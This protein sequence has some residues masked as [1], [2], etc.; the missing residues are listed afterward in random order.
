MT[1]NSNIRSEQT[2]EDTGEPLDPSTQARVDK[3]MHDLVHK[4][5]ISCP[6][7]F[8]W[9]GNQE[10]AD[11]VVLRIHLFG[12]MMREASSS[13]SF[14]ALQGITFHHDYDLALKEAVGADRSSPRPTKETGGLSV[15]MMV[16]V[17]GGVK[18]VMHESVAFDLASD[19]QE[20]SDQ[21]QHV[22]RHELCHVTDF[23]F[24]KGLIAERPDSVGFSGFESLM[25]P[26]AE[27][28]WDEFYANKYSSGSW[29]DPRTFLDLIRDTLPTIRKEI[30]DAIHA[31]RG[32]RDFNGLLSFTKA[33]VKFVAQCFGYAAGSLAA[34]GV[35]LAQA[36][37]GEHALLVQ[38][39][40]ID[41]WRQCFET[42]EELD[43]LRPDWESVLDIRKLFPA[44]VALLASFG[45]KYRPDGDRAYVEIAFPP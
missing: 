10:L 38:F 26:F 42:L 30:M 15:G 12:L 8:N 39:G 9:N 17:E 23:A 40:L 29:S 24:K 45:L 22:I 28:L 18:L 20:L 37:P 14:D 16:P 21:A 5:A 32:A 6:I 41:A 33:K 4:P 43:S 19:K 31:D 25:A 11:T 7:T 2:S 34:R 1:Q 35:T 13:I 36:A 27:T 44:C 3:L